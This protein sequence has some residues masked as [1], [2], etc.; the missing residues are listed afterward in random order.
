MA[1][2]DST[3]TTSLD[4]EHGPA[5]GVLQQLK[6]LF[7]VAEVANSGACPSSG[8]VESLALLFQTIL[9]ED[10]LS[11]LL[12]VWIARLQTPV[13]RQALSDPDS[14]RDQTHPARRLLAR[15]GSSA[16][17][18]GGGTLPCGALEQEIK[19]LV[20]LIEQYPEVGTRV[21][22]QANDEFEKF[23]ARFQSKPESLQKVDCVICQKDQQEA[24]SVQYLIALRDLLKEK[25]AQ[26][27]IR[28]F[29]FKVWTEVMAVTAVRKGLQHTDTL[30]LKKTATDL[31]GASGELIEPT[32]HSYAIR[33]IPL[34]LQRLRAGMTL[35]GL[36]LDDQDAH[37]NSIRETLGKAVASRHQAIALGA[38]ST[39]GK[40]PGYKEKT[41]HPASAYAEE[42]SGLEVVD[43]DPATSWRL[44]D[45]AL[46]EQDLNHIP[47][48]AEDS[49]LSVAQKK[50]PGAGP[51]GAPKVSIELI[52]VHGKP[53]EHRR[54][55]PLK[56]IELHHHRVAS[57]IRSLWSHK[58]C[59]IY[60]DKL[61]LDGGDGMGHNRIGFNQSAAQAMI[62]LADLHAKEFRPLSW[63]RVRHAGH[64]GQAV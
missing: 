31:I 55:E 50:E 35:L 61:I 8:G 42:L 19:R 5:K 13:M 34:L 57:V 29:L 53:I 21:Y 56:T 51:K 25:P 9:Q 2:T 45:C 41:A 4:D 33:K 43:D 54:D 20:L 49:S 64:A 59:G 12:R 36:P 14:F 23:L 28:D 63:D 30:W 11:P 38:P 48:P 6:R 60:I 18:F 15:F 1:R 52:R 58:E 47:L 24:L 3:S 32:G 10:R 27:E 17:G 39:L 26:V 40:L 46:V 37:I 16:M 44:W 22:E 7:S 62:A